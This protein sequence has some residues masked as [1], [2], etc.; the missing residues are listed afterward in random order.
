MAP[1]VDAVL[2]PGSLVLVT[3]VTGFVASVIADQLLSHSYRPSNRHIDSIRSSDDLH[4]QVYAALLEI[5]RRRK[6]IG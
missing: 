3:G 5:Y 1:P 4:L 2:E 6:R